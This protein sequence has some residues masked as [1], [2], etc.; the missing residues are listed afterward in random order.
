MLRSWVA[1]PL[2]EWNVSR[3]VTMQAQGVQQAASLQMKEAQRR[4]G[5]SAVAHPSVT[6]A[7]QKRRSWNRSI[8]DGDRRQLDKRV[9]LR[10]ESACSLVA[11]PFVPQQQQRA[12][13]P[14]KA[15]A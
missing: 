3:V 6:T 5:A 11:F 4:C 13:A 15:L 10:L 12:T 14:D 8:G 1:A 9:T 7:G 2:E